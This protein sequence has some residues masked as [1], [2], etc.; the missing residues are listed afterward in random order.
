M[1]YAEIIQSREWIPTKIYNLLI[2][3]SA[4]LLLSVSAQFTFQLPFTPV[5][6]T[7]QTLAVFLIAA[8]LGK[9]RGT[10]AVGL[11]LAQGAAGLPVF[12]GGRAG[13]PVLLGPTGGYL[14]GF[15]A[16]AYLIGGLVERGWD[17]T[18]VSSALSLTLGNS[19]IY[20]FGLT[21]L[22][23][24]LNLRDALFA[25]LYPFLIG[26]LLKILIA[27]GLLAASGFFKPRLL[28]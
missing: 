3:I 4:S 22:G 17:Q 2:V 19:L 8:L 14:L 20:L 21:W 7:A 28:N 9:K 26:D 15:L 10:A 27:S 16:A 13:V 1:S 11:Y 12:A 5:P 23:L 24:S 6:I 25:G 18:F